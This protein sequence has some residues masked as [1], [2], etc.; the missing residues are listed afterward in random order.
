MSA[1]ELYQQFAEVKTVNSFAWTY[2]GFLKYHCSKMFLAEKGNK[3]KINGNMPY[4]D[5]EIST[6]V[7]SDQFL[8]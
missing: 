1:T 7:L 8:V 5:M 6:S 2:N 4:P 3:K